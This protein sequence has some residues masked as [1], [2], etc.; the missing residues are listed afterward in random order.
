MDDI[1]GFAGVI[2]DAQGGSVKRARE[3]IVKF[4]QSRAITRGHQAEQA[5]VGL[6]AGV[7]KIGDLLGFHAGEYPGGFKSVHGAWPRNVTGEMRR[8]HKRHDA[9]ACYA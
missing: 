9:V 8:Q 3:T 5:R 7:G 4:A 1:L 6:V 2:E